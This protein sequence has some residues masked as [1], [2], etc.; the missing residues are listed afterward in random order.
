MIKGDSRAPAP[1]S[2]PSPINV[3]PQGKGVK[4]GIRV[5]PV[6]GSMIKEVLYRWLPL[7][8]PTDERGEAYPP[9]YSHFPHYGEEYFKQITTEQ[10]VTRVAKTVPADRVAEDQGQE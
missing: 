9:G 1:I 2:R 6:N 10:L 5:W 4:F 7:D 3:G 8:R